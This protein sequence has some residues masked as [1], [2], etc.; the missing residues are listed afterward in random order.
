MVQKPASLSCKDLKKLEA[1][2]ADFC[3]DLR[4]DFAR[5]APAAVLASLRCGTS[6][7]PCR[8]F[9]EVRLS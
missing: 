5:G 1:E 9:R 7:R 2:L 6:I 4:P 8:A 3:V